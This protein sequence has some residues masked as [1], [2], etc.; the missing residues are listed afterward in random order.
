MLDI[1]HSAGKA[2]SFTLVERILGPYWS[3]WLVC[4]LHSGAQIIIADRNDPEN[5]AMSFPSASLDLDHSF[6]S[7]G[8]EVHM[9]RERAF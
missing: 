9:L 4:L 8:D 6:N 2:T 3:P 1:L 5:A 7:V